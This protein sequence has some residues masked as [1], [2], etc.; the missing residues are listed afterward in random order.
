VNLATWNVRGQAHKVD[1]LESELKRMKI[2]ICIVTETKK[3]PKGTTDYILFYNGL[4]QSKKAASGVTVLLKQSWRNRVRSYNFVS[5]HIINI[6]LK[7]PKGYL[8]MVGVYTPEE[9]RKY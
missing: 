2:D 4:P 6:I 1:E 9:G 7:T 5:D 3:K 8:T